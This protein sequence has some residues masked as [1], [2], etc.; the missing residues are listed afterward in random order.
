[1]QNTGACERDIGVILEAKNIEVLDI[2]VND[3]HNIDGLDELQNLK[4]FAFD[5]SIMFEV[6]NWL[7]SS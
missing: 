2:G 7:K 5:K 4:Y 6:P 1:M 3:F